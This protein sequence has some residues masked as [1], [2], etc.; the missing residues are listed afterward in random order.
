MHNQDLCA[1]CY[2][3]DWTTVLTCLNNAELCQHDLEPL[4]GHSEQNIVHVLAANGRLQELKVLFDKN[5]VEVDS[6]DKLKRTP[7]HL[8][9]E[10][11]H[12]EVVKFLVVQGANVN[13]VDKFGKTPIHSLNADK[14]SGRVFINAAS[15]IEVGNDDPHNILQFL[16]QN[17]ANLDSQNRNGQTILHQ[18]ALNG[19]T[20]LSVTALNEGANPDLQDK[21]GE[22]PLHNAIG[23]LRGDTT[24]VLLAR[25]NSG[26][27][28][29]N[30]GVTPSD[31]LAKN[32][33]LAH[34]IALESVT[35]NL[36]SGANKNVRLASQRTNAVMAKATSTTAIPVTPEGSV[37]VVDDENTQSFCCWAVIVRKICKIAL[38]RYD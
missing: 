35:S 32:S 13:A 15:N 21:R 18:Y 8:A 29:N 37:V 3:R 2:K 31:L 26:H 34:G 10:F 11:R 16:A 4:Y 19:N 24:Q 28:T 1:A 27:I 5:S 25:S 22:T 30:E 12:L 23:E 9:S 33:R 36:G 7:L 17:G 20:R 6:K 14:A 38:S